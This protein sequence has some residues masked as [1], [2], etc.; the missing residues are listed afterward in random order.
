MTCIVGLQQ[1]GV[2]YIGGDSH[3]GDHTSGIELRADEKVFARD[4]LIIGFTWSY[5][6]GQLLRY[7]L[8]IP[9]HP[10]KMDDHEYLVVHFVD[11]IRECFSAKGWLRKDNNVESHGQFLLAYRRRLYTV[12]SDFSIAKPLPT[13]TR[14]RLPV[15]DVTYAAVGCGAQ[16]ALGAMH[17]TKGLKPRTR[18]RRALRAAS[19][20]SMGVRPPFVVLSTEGS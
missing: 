3:A 14:G 12:N 7:A 16:V 11:A 5:R 13:G 1:D 20:Y 6:M 8:E 10:K 18:I 17:A 2:V 9:K 19:Q 15:V 4:G